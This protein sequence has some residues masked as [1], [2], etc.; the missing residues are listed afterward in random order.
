MDAQQAAHK[1]FLLHS[2]NAGLL[3]PYVDSVFS[4]SFLQKS[5]GVPMSSGVQLREWVGLGV[6]R[7][8]VNIVFPPRHF[9]VFV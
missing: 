3:E 4:I 6:A 7:L 5:D 1:Y 9:L 8:L 2:S